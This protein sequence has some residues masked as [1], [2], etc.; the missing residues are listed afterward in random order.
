VTMNERGRRGRRKHYVRDDL[1]GG[2]SIGAA[3]RHQLPNDSQYVPPANTTHH[4][5]ARPGRGVPWRLISSHWSRAEAYEASRNVGALFPEY[6][7]VAQF[8]VVRPATHP[9]G[10]QASRFS[11]N[12]GE[13]PRK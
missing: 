3:T 8:S 12:R 1:M 9:T 11:C 7:Y 4:L 10:A 2:K 5:Y 6:S 13:Q